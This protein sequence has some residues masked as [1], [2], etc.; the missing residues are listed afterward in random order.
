L[1]ALPAQEALRKAARADRFNTSGGGGAAGAP[2]PADKA[3]ARA[4]RFGTGA[5]ELVDKEVRAPAAGKAG[6]KR[7]GAAAAAPAAAEFEAKKKVGRGAARGG[8]C[9]SPCMSASRAG[10]LWLSQCGGVDAWLADAYVAI[11]HA[12]PRALL[13]RA[14]LL[15]RHASV[16][17]QATAE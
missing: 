2:A 10:P 12:L 9:L 3:K 8:P 11:V 5:K 4:E 15:S 6:G 17:R 7:G 1:A 16:F 13:S 14:G